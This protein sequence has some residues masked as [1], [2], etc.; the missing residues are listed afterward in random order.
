MSIEQ[1]E[2][3]SD[4]QSLA[5]ETSG[6]FRWW[7]WV[8]GLF[9]LPVLLLMLISMVN[10]RLGNVLTY[11]RIWLGALAVLAVIVIVA[12]ATAPETEIRSDIFETQATLNDGVLHLML[13][14]D[15]PD[16]TNI[17]VSISRSYWESGNPDAYSIDYFQESSTVGQWRE[18]RSIE[19]NDE[20]WKVLLRD[21][22]QKMSQ[23]GSGFDVSSIGDSVRVY[24]VVPLAQDDSRF[25]DRNEKLVGKAVSSDGLRVVRNEISLPSTL[26]LSDSDSF[27]DPALSYDDLQVGA[28]YILSDRTA[29]VAEPDPVDPAAALAQIVYAPAGFQFKVVSRPMLDGYRWYEVLVL[30]RDNNELGFGWINSVALVGQDLQRKSN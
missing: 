21:E 18:P 1:P 11:G 27:V 26:S 2:V 12:L 16:Y 24:M 3:Q 13:N 9:F 17:S 4:D 19:V 25:G 5:K 6:G 20:T 8:L 7:Q 22:Q 10:R 15:L 28:T 23:I 29:V 30:D 14:T